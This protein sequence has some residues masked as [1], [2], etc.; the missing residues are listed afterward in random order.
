MVKRILIYLLT[1]GGIASSAFGQS[2]VTR[3]SGGG[4]PTGAAGGDLS[5]T[6]PNPSLL[7]LSGLTAGSYGSASQ[8]AGFNLDN[9]GRITGTTLY[10]IT[11]AAIGAAGLATANTFALAQTF[12]T[13][14]VFSSLTANSL[15]GLDGSK[16]LVV[17]VAGTDYLLPTGSGAGLTA[18]NATNITTGTLTDARLSTNV[19][20]LNAANVFTGATPNRFATGLAL[21]STGVN[22]AAFTTNNDGAETTMFRARTS[23][24]ST[25]LRFAP[26][27]AAISSLE[28]FGTDF[29][30]DS[31]NFERLL[32]Q[33]TGSGSFKIYTDAAGSGTRRPIGFGANGTATQLV[34]NPDGSSAFSGPL[35]LAG[36]AVARLVAKPATATSA[37]KPGDYWLDT[38]NNKA[39]FYLGDGTTHKWAQDSLTTYVP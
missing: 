29:Q 2:A 31:A 37:G 23:N 35:T 38:V 11:P 21:G 32:M 17:K 8:V 13:A 15:L 7:T 6:Y 26:N 27:G 3:P 19:P 1:A 20:L 25:V 34:L 28:F 39:V 14:P 9:K 36:F 24:Q 22:A 4:A 12:S 10:T 5:G 16:N 18:L 33:S 30:S